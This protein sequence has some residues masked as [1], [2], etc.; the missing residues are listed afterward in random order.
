MVGRLDA[1]SMK[2]CTQPL[3]MVESAWIVTETAMVNFAN[4]ACQIT[5]F[6]QSKTS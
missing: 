3:V 4:D 2:K 6:P 1:G 5:S